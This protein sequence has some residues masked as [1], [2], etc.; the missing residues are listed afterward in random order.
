MT[1]ERWERIAHTFD[2]AT[3]APEEARAAVL[4]RL[5]GAD[6]A[7]RAEVE[8]LL[9]SAS[10]AAAAG[11]LSGTA[12]LSG[13]A[14]AP[15][16]PPRWAAGARL[17]GRFEIARLLGRGGMG[18]VYAARDLRLDI[19][20]A[21]KVM[22]AGIAA[23]PPP[24][25]RFKREVLTARGVSHRHV[26]RIYDLAVDPG[27]PAV[28]FLSMELLPGETLAEVLRRHGPPP[29]AQARRWL[30]QVAAGLDAA[31][32][33]GVVHGDFKPGNVL[34]RAAGADGAREAVIT[35]FGLARW[36]AAAPAGARGDGPIGTLAYMAP[37]QLAGEAATP[38]SD[39]YAFGLVA[40]EVLCGRPAFEAKGPLGGILQRL[41][42]GPVPPGVRR[43]GLDPAWDGRIAACLADD[44]RRRPARAGLA[45]AAGPLPAPR[46]RRRFRPAWAGGAVAAAG[47]ALALALALARPAPIRSQVAAGSELLVAPVVNATGVRN[48][49]AVT[50]LL[51]EQLAQSAQFRL[52]G[53]AETLGPMR[54]LRAPA[55]DLNLLARRPLLA[56]QVAQ[57]LGA[58]LVVFASLARSGGRFRLALALQRVG[59]NPA[60]PARTWRVSETADGMAGVF[61]ALHAGANWIRVRAGEPAEALAAT[62]QPPQDIATASWPAAED[63]SRALAAQAAGRAPRAIAWLRR[64][65][66]ADPGFALAQARLGAL[67]SARGD[68]AGASAAYRRALALARQR[69]LSLRRRLRLEALTAA[70]SRNWTAAL[71]AAQAYAVLYPLDPWGWASQA[72][73][74]ARLGAPA[75]ARAARQRATALATRG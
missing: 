33:A 6:A 25:D 62:D 72:V 73:A 4:T 40:Y 45:L 35:D 38:A 74:D 9:A 43:P 51:R 55:A 26:C 31:H 54:R 69:R 19:D 10:A 39:I 68:A 48:L 23:D 71:R 7:L 44:P 67:L 1:P 29:E 65:A 56:R 61:D 50:A 21:L 13:A 42:P 2:A 32:A 24:L 30:E 15:E 59:A 34:F 57:R 49:D 70:S 41:R 36:T 66:A 16:S 52:A 63:Y 75:A 46:R 27:P 11:F 20:V 22:R 17:A 53:A 5:C 47:A 60:V 8:A 3:A 12:P 14:P 58:P 37:E 64:A 28:P 18:E